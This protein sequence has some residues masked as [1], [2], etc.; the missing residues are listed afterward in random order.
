MRQGEKRRECKGDLGEKVMRV[1]KTM[2]EVDLKG[3]LDV[4]RSSLMVTNIHL[5]SS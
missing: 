1:C 5:L 3:E 2:L 4:V